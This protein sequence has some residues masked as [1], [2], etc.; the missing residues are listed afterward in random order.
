MLFRHEYIFFARIDWFA[1]DRIAVAVI[2]APKLEVRIMRYELSD[3]EWRVINPMLS[4]KPCGVPRVDD[5]RILN[6][7]V[8]NFRSGAPWRDLPEG[9]GPNTTCYNRS[10]HRNPLRKTRS[11]LSCHHQA[12]IH[13]HLATC[14]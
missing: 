13:P 6:E 5:R 9:F 7:I 12:R 10:T 2:Q 11:Q 14:F 3:Y 4:N 8:W 1:V